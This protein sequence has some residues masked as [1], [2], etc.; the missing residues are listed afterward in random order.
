[1]LWKKTQREGGGPFYIHSCV[2]E[3]PTQR[4]RT[5]SHCIVWKKT[6]HKGGGPLVLHL[7]GRKHNVE[8]QNPFV[9]CLCGWKH[10]G[11]GK[12]LLVVSVWKETWREGV[13]PL[14]LHPFA[15]KTRRERVSPLLSCLWCQQITTALENECRARFWGRWSGGGGSSIYHPRKRAQ[16]L[17]FEGSGWWGTC[18]M[19]SNKKRKRNIAGIPCTPTPCVPF[20]LAFSLFAFEVAA[21]QW[22]WSA[23]LLIIPWTN[24]AQRFVNDK[25]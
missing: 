21:C 7:C 5:P 18:L 25:Q 8:W 19:V 23:R 24:N 4:G 3:N 22:L 17:V 2:E 14:L 15:K 6:Q 12:P 1:M 20:L 16:T 9:S 10:N 13:S 11:K